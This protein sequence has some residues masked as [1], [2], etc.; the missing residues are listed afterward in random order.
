[1]LISVERQFVFVANLKTA[2]TSIERALGPAADIVCRHTKLGKHLSLERIEARF[3]WVFRPYPIDR[4]VV[5]GV[6]RHPVDYLVSL[7]NSHHRPQGAGGRPSTLGIDFDS[8]VRDWSDTSWQANAQAQMFWR[9]DQIGVDVLIDFA[10]LARQFRL[11]QQHLGCFGP[12]GHLNKSE[13]VIG[14]GDIAPDTL[15][16][17]ERRYAEDLALYRAHAGRVHLGG[18]WVP[19]TTA[20]LAALPGKAVP[21]TGR[22]ARAW[23]GLRLALGR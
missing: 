19:I 18:D 20:A 8:F 3:P 23:G 14:R 2:S 7:Y 10:D 9:G 15:A 16:E 13:V 12:L 17:I 11:V 6:M 5:F 4:M 21:K 22:L 1:M